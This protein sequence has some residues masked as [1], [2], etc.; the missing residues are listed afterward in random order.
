MS[1]AA[2]DSLFYSPGSYVDRLDCAD[3]FPAVQPLEVEIGAGDGSFLVQYAAAHPGINLIGVER[4]MGR[5]T[6]IDKRGR[7]DGLA[8]LRLMRI[9]ANYF[10][11]Y[12][13][14]QDSV[15]AF[16]IYFP[17]PWPKVKHEKNRLI[18]PPFLKPLAAVLKPGGHVYLRTD[19]VPYFTQMVEVFGGAEEFKGVETPTDLKR[20]VTDFETGFNAQGIAT[21]YAAYR[22]SK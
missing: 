5:I 1:S 7:R 10:V 17:D 11:Q 18:Q 15:D 14:P 21:N 2:P 16:H 8:N 3:M 9:E 22:L 13:L 12:L 20:V 6:K 4:L 19:N